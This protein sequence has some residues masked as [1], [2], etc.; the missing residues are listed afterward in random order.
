ML[1]FDIWRLGGVLVEIL[2]VH[3][4][5]LQ[6]RFSFH[7]RF[8]ANRCTSV[9]YSPPRLTDREEPVLLL[10]R[11][12]LVIPLVHFA[13]KSCIIYIVNVEL[14]AVPRNCVENKRG[15]WV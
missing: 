6:H 14:R 2:N 9:G 7:I 8:P 12:I 3:L 13:N 5:A 1:G 11:N 4:P 15:S 10:I